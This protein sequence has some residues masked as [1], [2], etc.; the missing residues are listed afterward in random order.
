MMNKKELGEMII[1][2]TDEF[3]RMAK[4]ILKEDADCQDAVQEAVSKAFAKINTLRQEKY[5]KTW[6]IRILLN[7][8]YAILRKRNR[9]TIYH[10]EISKEEMAQ[11]EYSDLYQ[12]LMK[13]E[14]EYRLPLVL[15][16]LNQYTVKEIS[17][18][19][20]LGE[21]AVKMRLSRG[22]KKMRQMYEQED[23]V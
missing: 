19:L 17:Q 9:E 13:L 4:S 20:N 22:R 16:Y 7:E 8:C 5:A 21:S 2:G 18:I 12:K 10:E 15:Y 1:E 14:I 6:F 11:H 23:A 3:Y